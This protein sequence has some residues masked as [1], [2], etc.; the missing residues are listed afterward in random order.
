[1]NG[2]SHSSILQRQTTRSDSIM[3]FKK[4][5]VMDAREGDAGK[6]GRV[7]LSAAVASASTYVPPVSFG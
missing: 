5:R 7:A 3:E 4:R 1:M 6:K 2:K